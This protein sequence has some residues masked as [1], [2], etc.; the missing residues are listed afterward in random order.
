MKLYAN[1]SYHVWMLSAESLIE[2]KSILI[3]DFGDIS[4]FSDE[5]IE[6][7]GLRL[8]RVSETILKRK[9]KIENQDLLLNEGR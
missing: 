1:A 6:N 8:I 7:L 4:D 5:N 3:K 2:L 9:I